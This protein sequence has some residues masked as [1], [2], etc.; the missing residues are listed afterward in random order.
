MKMSKG[1]VT[2]EMYAGRINAHGKITSLSNGFKLKSEQPFSLF[3]HPKSDGADPDATVVMVDCKLYQ[4]DVTSPC[5]FT[6]NCWDAPAVQEIEANG[7]DLTKYDVYWGSGGD[8][9]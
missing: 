3:V 2:P 5:P 4:D 7:V 1:I 9:A 6:A 8:V